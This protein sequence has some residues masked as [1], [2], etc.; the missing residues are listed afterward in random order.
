M[1]KKLIFASALLL[2]LCA[3]GETTPTPKTVATNTIPATVSETPTSI[4]VVST[5]LPVTTQSLENEATIQFRD[6]FKEELEPGWEW[7][8]EKNALWS[9]SITP[10]FLTINV[11]GG[12][13]NL[14]N[15]S[16]LLLRPAPEGNFTIETYLKFTPQ[17]SNQFAGL[18][19]YESDKTYILAGEE[20]C[21]P[22]FG[23]V[24]RGIYMDVYQGGDLQIPRN[25]TLYDEDAVYLRLVRSEDTVNLFVSSNGNIWYRANTHKTTMNIEKIGLVTGQS[26]QSDPVPAQFD[27]FLVSPNN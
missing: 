4:S 24:G 17:H 20:Y 3:C 7:V 8:N 21:P 15:I 10:D 13:I 16:N 11:I 12:Y 18:I 9:L 5:P 14:G 19:L 6:D 23:C 2:F 22:V 26:L 25:P 1:I 27:Y